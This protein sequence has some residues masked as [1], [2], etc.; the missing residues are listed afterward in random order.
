MH[1]TCVARWHCSHKHNIMIHS[2]AVISNMHTHKHTRTHSH[3]LYTH[4][5]LNQHLN[6]CLFF[7]LLHKVILKSL[8]QSQF[9]TT[10]KV[11]KHG[12]S[13]SRRP[14]AHPP[15]RKKKNY[16]HTLWMN[17]ASNIKLLSQVSF[18]VSF[19]PG[20]WAAERISDQQRILFFPTSLCLHPRGCAEGPFAPRS[21]HHVHSLTQKSPTMWSICLM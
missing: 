15:K 6:R 10:Q 13:F 18:S 21:C 16:P 3:T 8:T 4:S 14:H 11:M 7:F 9:V 12:S 5:Y 19:L 1:F 20:S 2:S 17:T